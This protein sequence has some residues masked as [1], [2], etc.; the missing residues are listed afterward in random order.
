VCYQEIELPLSLAISWSLARYTHRSTDFICTR[1]SGNQ[2]PQSKTG[3]LC[4]LLS[5]EGASVI[6]Q[7]NCTLAHHQRALILLYTWTYPIPHT[8]YQLSYD[9]RE[10]DMWKSLR[11]V[12]STLLHYQI[13][14]IIIYSGN[15]SSL[16]G[17]KGMIPIS[18]LPILCNR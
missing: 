6:A 15:T 13:R 14:F 9:E 4:I 10:R 3:Y 8:L 11:M 1:G 18:W 12:E 7:G 5:Q 16:T 2:S 17:A